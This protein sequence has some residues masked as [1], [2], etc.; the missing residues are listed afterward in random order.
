MESELCFTPSGPED[1]GVEY[2]CRV[3]HETLQKTTAEST[4]PLPLRVQ[5]QL[6]Q[7]QVLPD[8]DAPRETLFA[9]RI[10]NFYPQKI[11]E[12]RWKIDGK[13]WERSKPREISPNSDGTFTATSMLRVPSRSLTGPGLRVRVSVQ[14]GHRDPPVERELCLGDA[15]VLKPPEVSDILNSVSA[16]G[17][18]TLSCRITG[19]FPGELSV[20]WLQKPRPGSVP[21][22][23]QDSAEH[24]IDPGTAVLAPDGKS[25]QQETTLS[26]T[27]HGLGAEYICRVGHVS[28]GT[29]VERSSVQP[30]LSQIQVLPDGD[31]P[32]ETRFTIRIENFYPQHIHEIRWKVD[33]KPWERSEPSE[34]SPNPD[35]TFT[36][37]SVWRVPSR[38][39]TGPGLRVRVCVQHGPGDPPVERELCLGDAECLKGKVG[40]AFLFDS[41][42]SMNEQQFSLIRKFM[43]EFAAVQFSLDVQTE[44]DFTNYTQNPNPQELLRDVKHMKVLTDTFKAIKHLV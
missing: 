2:Q 6:S 17:R 21:V 29:P 26:L 44:F 43:V 41:Y 1:D 30:Q 9:V 18:V 16:E 5:P 36:A 4:G 31:A 32:Q 33:G 25:F 19:H 8:G 13:P 14:H 15:D 20:T 10:E 39:L 11:H 3:E 42:N 40:L 7:I 28:L 37:T 23:L 38:S 12:I 34:I 35:G 24:S 27:Q 22:T